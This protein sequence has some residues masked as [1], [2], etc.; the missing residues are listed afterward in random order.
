M[1][2][3]PIVFFEEHVEVDVQELSN[4]LF[5]LRED[6]LIER[7]LLTDQQV[8]CAVLTLKVVKASVL[9][10]NAPLSIQLKKCQKTP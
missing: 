7:Q 4:E 2:E 1:D 9:T 3:Y 6:F 8:I 5:V 10:S